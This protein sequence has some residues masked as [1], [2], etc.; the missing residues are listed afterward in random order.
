[1]ND[2]PNH[3]IFMPID[4]QNQAEDTMGPE[5]TQEDEDDDFEPPYPQQGL[6]DQIIPGELTPLTGF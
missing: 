2:L 6:D 1:M 5:D 4:K 3:N